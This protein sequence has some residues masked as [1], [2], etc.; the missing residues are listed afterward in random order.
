ME[1]HE[2]IAGKLF[3]GGYNCAQSVFCA[4]CG[5]HGMRME[6]AA[7]VSSSFGGGMGRLREVCGALSG[8]FMVVGCL[9]GGYEPGD[10][11][12]KSRHYRMIQE[13]GAKF[14][15]EYGTLLCRDILGL[16]EGPSEP[17]PE[18]HTPQYLASRP[19]PGCVAF[20]ARLVDEFL[21]EH[22]ELGGEASL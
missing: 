10:R 3:A 9:C 1:S 14:R 19:C 16:G 15:A 18:A 5:V 11:E 20:G 2:Q 6:D 8:A 17:E 22:P 13:L 7:R 21:A 12:A 4:F